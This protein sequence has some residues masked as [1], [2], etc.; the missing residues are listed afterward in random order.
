MKDK[1]CGD[2]LKLSYIF[3]IIQTILTF[4]ALGYLIYQDALFLDRFYPKA[5]SNRNGVLTLILIL[6]MLILLFLVWA[7]R[8]PKFKNSRTALFFFLWIFNAVAVALFLVVCIFGFQ[9]GEKDKAYQKVLAY[10][11]NPD[12]DHSASDW[13]M[14]H[15]GQKRTDMVKY[16]EQRAT[17]FVVPYFLVMLVWGIAQVLLSIYLQLLKPGFQMPKDARREDRKT[18]KKIDSP[19]PI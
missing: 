13:F 4:G 9:K 18:S 5:V 11:S 2:V 10:L 16:V 1:R 7:Y 8:I 15:Y 3:L 17:S 6:A 12:R 19:E 14:A